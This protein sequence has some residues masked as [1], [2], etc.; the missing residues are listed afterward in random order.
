VDNLTLTNTHL[1]IPDNEKTE[2]EVPFVEANV[3][4]RILNESQINIVYDVLM[5]NYVQEPV[6]AAPSSYYKVK[7]YTVKSNESKTII[8]S[9][10]SN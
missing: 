10:L 9:S 5:E 3:A 2:T 6:L 8:M 1:V 4:I 7:S